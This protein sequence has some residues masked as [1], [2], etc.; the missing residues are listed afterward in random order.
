MSATRSAHTATTL[1]SP[2]SSGLRGVIARRPITAFLVLVFSLAYPLMALPI[3]AFRGVI[4]GKD[5]LEMLPIA[6]DEVAGFLL[7]LGALLPATLI[8]TWSVDGGPGVRR[9]ARRT[10]RW[11]IGVGWWVAIFTALPALTTGFA[12]LM[13]DSLKPVNVVQLF[14]TQLGLLLAN[15]AFVNLWEELAWSGFMQTRLEARHNVFVAALI[16]MVPFAFAHAP[17][18]FF[19]DG[20]VT[21]FSLL[22]GLGLYV[23]LG[24]FFR[25]ML[26]VVLRGTRDSVLAVA[27]LHSVFNRTNNNNGI[28]ASLV[29]GEARTIT[30]LVAV[31]VLTLAVSV[32]FRRRLTRAYRRQ[33]D[34]VPVEHINGGRWNG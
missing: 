34:A 9:L 30:M 25:P 24:L 22:V 5:L 8:V 23:V 32:I 29:D 1:V 7:T 14:L 31:A 17:L 27:V 11:R 18:T 28:A 33:L 15:F 16:T 26:A 21:L 6:P 10:T 4:P 3:L 13:G 20:P 2:P 12:V 19:G